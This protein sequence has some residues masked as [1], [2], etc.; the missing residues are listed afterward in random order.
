MTGDRASRRLHVLGEVMRVCASSEPLD[1]VLAAVADRLASLVALDGVGLGLVDAGRGEFT[2]VDVA[3]R[4]LGQGPWRDVRRPLAN[5]L[6]AR[7]VEQRTPLRVDDFESL[8]VPLASREAFAARGYRSAVLAP[9]I[10][11][12]AVTGA[13]AVAARRPGAFDDADV[14]VVTELAQPL[15][16]ALD[17]RRLLEESGHLFEERVRHARQ[18][19]ALLEAGRAVTASLDVQE[20]IRVI[21]AEARSVLGA[22]SC[23][24]VTLDPTSGDL[25]GT[26]SLDLPP[27]LSARIRLK[28]GEGIGGLAFIERRPMQ[29]ED[30]AQDPRQR[31][32]E[33]TE[34]SAFRSMLAAP[35]RV[36]D[37]AV[38]VI[39]VFRTDVHRFSPD[40]EALLLALADQ[41]AIALEHARLYQRLEDV[42][43]ERTREL[44][45]QKRFVEIVLETLPLGVFVL[46]VK[47]RVVRAN[48]HGVRVLGCTTPGGSRIIDLVPPERQA[49][50]AAFLHEAFVARR[51]LLHEQDV[52]MAGEPRTFRFTAAPFEADVAHLVLLVEDVTL[53]KRLER[54][55]LL[56]ERLTTAGHMAAGV[57]HELNNPLATIAGCAESLLMRTREAPLAEA[58]EIDDFRRY[59]GLIEEEAYRCKDI[60]GSL[61]QFVRE[62][63]SRR[64]STDLNALVVKTVELLMH[65]KRFAG[66]PII[67]E[68]APDLPRTVVNE[69]QL[70]QV[71]LGIAANALEAMEA[72]GVLTIRTRRRR[73]EIDVEF[74][75]EGPGVPDEMLARVFDPFFTTKPP[76]QGTGLGLAI[77]QS[78]VTDH[79]GRIEVTSNVGK[80][81]IFRVVVPT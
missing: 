16:V 25:V 66:R 13:L 30:L 31:F 34:A 48:G 56:T 6:L 69:G 77:A 72:G 21:I 71:F 23:G 1:A 10:V 55:M 5:S 15:A 38:G 19:R 57:A 53:A 65:Q 18:T 17:Q 78:I 49:A 74:E 50:L 59:L 32:P 33:L 58:G 52:T 75:D 60:T 76:G 27:E 2:I 4:S 29:S 35:L 73:D 43:A 79:R 22:A 3:A 26:A 42:V 45:E 63:D 61:L 9:L 12:G 24:M 54:Q 7:V 64:A 8:S 44:D 40:E 67:T 62:P 28:P 14:E 11:R 37:R 81:S 68:L 20:T 47:L 36:G 41:A 51:V 39:Y 80:G 46:D 70:R